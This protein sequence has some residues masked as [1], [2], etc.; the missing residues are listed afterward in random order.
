MFQMMDVFAGLARA[1]AKGK[2]LG[3]P[4]VSEAKVQAIKQARV[5]DMGEWRIARELKVGGGTV[6]RIAQEG[7]AAV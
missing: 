3:R 6:R 4:H 1:K 7:C 5:A 2:K